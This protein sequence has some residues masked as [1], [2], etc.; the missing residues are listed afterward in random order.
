[1]TSIDLSDTQWRVQPLTQVIVKVAASC[2]LNCTYCHIY[3]GADHTSDRSPRLMTDAVFEALVERV[4]RHCAASGQEHVKLIFHGGEPCQAGPARI[5]RWCQWASQRLHDE[6]RVGFSI[7]TNGTLL[8][9]DWAAVLAEHRVGI[10]VSLDGPPD[11]NDRARIDHLGRGTHDAVIRGIDRL[12]TAGLEY[13]ILSVI[14]FGIDPLEVHRHLLSLEPREISYLFP[15]ETHDTVSEAKHAYGPTPCADFLV[16]VFDEWWFNG[17][18][19]LRVREFW[20][21]AQMILGGRS[22]TDAFGGGPVPF[23]TVETDGAIHGTDKL[24]ACEDGMSRTGLNVVNDDFTDVRR[25]RTIVAAAAAGLGP[26]P[27]CSGCAEVFTCGGG[28]LANRYSRAAGFDN[29]SVW[30]EDIRIVFD[31]IRRRLGVD[32]AETSRRRA[33]LQASAGREGSQA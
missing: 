30:C 1:M 22:T 18:M 25:T 33:L 19:D 8:D 2:N 28:H 16:P 5:D 23:I 13:S 6:V 26:A 3:Q 14:P 17:S 27:A 21:I 24:R 11:L 7:Q 4:S 15:A 31:H 9:D 20:S 32:A 12:R 10:G 29:R